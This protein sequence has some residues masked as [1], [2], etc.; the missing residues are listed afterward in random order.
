MTVTLDPGD[1]VSETINVDETAC[2]LPRWLKIK[3]AIPVIPYSYALAGTAALPSGHRRAVLWDPSTGYDVRDYYVTPVDPGS[4]EAD[5]RAVIFAPNGSYIVADGLTG[6]P[7]I[8]TPRV[9]LMTNAPSR[10]V[11]RI[12]ERRGP[13]HVLDPDFAGWSD[14]HT[15]PIARGMEL[16]VEYRGPNGLELVFR[17]QIYQVSDRDTVEVTAYDRLMDLYQYSGQYQN[18][19]G[20]TQE[21][22]SRTGDDG[23][24]YLYSAS[25]EVGTMVEVKEADVLR[26]DALSTLTQ[27]RAQTGFVVHDMPSATD[28]NSVSHTPGAGSHIKRVA[29]KVFGRVVDSGLTNEAILK[30]RAILYHRVGVRTFTVVAATDWQS[31]TISGSDTGT[32]TW[33]VDWVVPNSTYWIGAEYSYEVTRGSYSRAGANTTDNRRTVTTIYYSNNGQDWTVGTS[34]YMPE[35]SVDFTEEHSVSLSDVAVTGSTV[36][37]AMGA[38]ASYSGTYLSTVDLA[39]SA[40]LDYF[41]VNA[42]PLAQVLP[43]LIEGAGLIPDIPQEVDLGSTTFYQASTYNYLDL[44]QEMLQGSSYAM[45]A[46][47]FEAGRVFVGPRHTLA[48]DPVLEVTTAPDGSGERIVTAHDLTVNWAAERATVAVI[49]ENVTSSGLPIALETDD[50][51][52]GANGA[53]GSLA[54]DL[55][56]PLRGVSA[57]S[58]LGTHGMLAVATSHKIRELHTNLLDGS[59]TLAGYRTDLWDQTSGSAA[60]VPISITVPEYGL[61][62]VK[63]IPTEIELGDGAT[64]VTLDNVRTSERNEVANSMARTEDSISNAVRSYPATVYIFGRYYGPR[65]FPG[66]TIST[67]PVTKVEC[68]QDL[69]TAAAT[70]SDGTYIKTVQDEVGYF[71]V[72]AVFPV[73]PGGYAPDTPIVAVRITINGTAYTAPLENPLY[74]MGGQ[75]LHVDIRFQ[76]FTI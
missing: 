31:L 68:M 29:T 11:L 39:V 32:L 56:S 47:I 14:G 60:G 61:S 53:D 22:R 1:A 72:C 16:T 73:S 30:A 66:E 41:P 10:A 42:M 2:T 40:Y 3:R 18:H 57:D 35:I 67:S 69:N 37:I 74:A 71:H 38:I 24:Y 17:G 76:G 43:D 4:T 19:L 64:V 52:V 49:A 23:T 36:K 51:I 46:N 25:S 5:W 27:S 62:G 6:I 33:S 65:C 63:V 13:A 70:Q 44:L 15:G 26:I 48:E 12:A 7:T 75:M 28:S 34:D 50:R 45:S 20:R 54:L 9:R 59:L 58:T 55:Q 8:G 21:W